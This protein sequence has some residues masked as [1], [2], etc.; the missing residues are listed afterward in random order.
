M[1]TTVFALGRDCVFKIDGTE[2]DG[3]SDVSVRESTTEADASSYMGTAG[4]SAVTS[5]TYSI[6]IAV[7]DIADARTIVA[8]RMEAADANGFKNP[9]LLHIELSG[10]LIDIDGYF[11][12]HEWDADEPIDGVIV[13][14]FELKEWGGPKVDE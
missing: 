2:Y 13:P 7:P 1:P 11:T 6:S 4:A 9:A 3:I 8:K 12:I 14:R 10:G 5:R